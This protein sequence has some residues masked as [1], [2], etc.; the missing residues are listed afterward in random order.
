MS[1]TLVISPGYLPV[2]TVPVHRAVQLYVDGKA[3]IERAQDFQRRKF[4]VGSLVRAGMIRA[5]VPA[6]GGGG[7][8]D[9]PFDTGGSPLRAAR[10]LS[11]PL[12]RR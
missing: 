10:L 7:E 2:G 5:E 11:G 1:M 8:N 4:A 9:R 12:R 6:P 3:E